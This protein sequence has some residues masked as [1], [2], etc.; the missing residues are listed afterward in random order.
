LTVT[1]IYLISYDITSHEL[2]S[3]I[4]SY[5]TTY[6][7]KKTGAKILS[8]S[9]SSRSNQMDLKKA[10]LIAFRTPPSDSTG[11]PHDLEHL[12]FC[13]SRKYLTKEPFVDFLRGSLRTFLN[14]MTFPNRTIYLFSTRNE[15]DFFNTAN[16]YL[17]AAF[18]PRAVEDE[19]VLRHVFGILCACV[20]SCV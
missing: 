17:D 16:V 10:F 20:C 6:N 11:V 3:E 18:F 14:A 1:I 15:K 19:F 2:I 5:A 12:V 7:H 13:G 8:L 4:D 9:S